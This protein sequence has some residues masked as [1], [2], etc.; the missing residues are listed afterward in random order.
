MRVEQRAQPVPG[1]RIERRYQ[2][3]DGRRIVDC[4]RGAESAIGVFLPS[5][6][7][8]A[9]REPVVKRLHLFVV[10]KHIVRRRHSQRQPQVALGRPPH[11][12]E[13]DYGDGR[14][15]DAR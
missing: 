13:G 3:V 6:I 4:C 11:E 7:N 8:L 15:R 10:K 1:D 12:K 2:V 14:Q 5:R 9:G